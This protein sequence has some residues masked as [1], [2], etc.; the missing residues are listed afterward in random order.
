MSE[1]AT[2]KEIDF[3]EFLD[4][5]NNLEDSKIPF[6]NI[7]PA[8]SSVVFKN[9]GREWYPNNW[10]QGISNIGTYQHQFSNHNP[11]KKTLVIILGK[12]EKVD[13]GDFDVVQDME[14]NMIVVHW[15]LRHDR[16]LIFVHTSLKI[17]HQK[18]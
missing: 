3:Q 12:V 1:G 17:Y 16:N 10:R 11:D 2:D 7:N 9:S 6:Q 5:F 4:G 8:M 13:W 15:D 14:W 18:S